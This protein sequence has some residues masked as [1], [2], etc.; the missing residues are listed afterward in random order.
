MKEEVKLNMRLKHLKLKTFLM[1]KGFSEDIAEGFVDEICEIIDFPQSDDY[2]AMVF[3]T[4]ISFEEY[5]NILSMLDE[6]GWNDIFGEDYILECIEEYKKEPKENKEPH[7]NKNMKDTLKLL[8]NNKSKYNLY[9]GLVDL[10]SEVPE[11][12][13]NKKELFEALFLEYI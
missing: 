1:D 3:D 13:N 8:K 9:T 2:K 4:S 10:C 7:R 5:F 6:S 12:I 11:P